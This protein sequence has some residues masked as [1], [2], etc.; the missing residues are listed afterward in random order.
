MDAFWVLRVKGL[1]PFWGKFLSSGS[2][3]V[4]RGFERDIPDYLPA[5]VPFGT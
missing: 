1:G 2:W 4:M 3:L 5:Y